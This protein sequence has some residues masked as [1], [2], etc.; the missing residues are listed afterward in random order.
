MHVLMRDEKKGR[1][2]QA[3][4]NK[5]MYMY[6]RVCYR[7]RLAGM[8]QGWSEAT[9]TEAQSI[10]SWSTDEGVSECTVL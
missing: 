7:G 5:Q 9:L 8:V 4:S 2:K 10:Y 3:R 6:V 1:K